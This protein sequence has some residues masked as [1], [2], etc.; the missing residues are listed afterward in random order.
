MLTLLCLV[1]FLPFVGFLILAFFGARLTKSIIAGVG[2]GSV[3]V[4]A[5]LT[6]M[7]GASF[8]GAPP[9][10]D[11]FTQTLWSWIDV[12]NFN[13]AI[14]FHLD[15]LSL[16]MMF[17][18]TFVGFFIHL[19]SVEFMREEEGY[20]RFFAYMNLFVGSMLILVMADNLLLLYLGWE[21]VGLCSYLLIGFWY[22]DPANGYAA[23]KA[24]VVTRVGDTAMAIGLFIL[25]TNLGTLNI[26]EILQQAPQEWMTGSGIAIAAAALLLGGAV[27]KSAQLPLQTWLP[28]AMAGPTPVSALIHAATMVTAGVYLI[29][30]THVLFQLAPI[31]QTLVAVVGALTLLIAGFSAL[32]QR[33][34]KRVLAYSTISQIGYMFLALGVGAYAAAMFH[35]MT[36]AFFKALLFLGAGV[37]IHCLHHEHDMFKMGGLKQRMPVTFWTFL[38]G[39]A[40]LA[41]LP[42]VTAGFYSKDM[43]LWLT[44]SSEI[45]SPWLWAAGL[46]G[47]F[48]TAVYTFRMIFITFYGKARTEPDKSPGMAMTVPLVV[49]AILSIAGGFVET[50]AT[51]GHI[52]AFSSQLHT[53]LADVSALHPSVSTELLFQGIAALVTILGI[54]LAYRFYLQKPQAVRTS[55]APAMSGVQSFWFHGW[56]FDWLYDRLFVMPY[57][58]FANI[59]RGDA[60]DYLYTG[61]ARFLQAV[62]HGLRLTQTGR[63]RNYAAVIAAGTIIIIAMV[64]ML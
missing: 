41:A 15:A 53:V 16:A 5:L 23:R 54:F 63:V 56:C 3:G 17:V 32:T 11:A 19:Y 18:I 35:F 61:L 45:G 58:W 4:A 27:G 55:E 22:R 1:P 52:T 12:G 57:L 59:N 49:L 40:S 10:G 46:L 6:I 60:T 38:I 34:I 8:I 14:A 25:F 7:I 36:H 48:V 37:I 33:D 20:S 44:W 42:L 30:R 31:V 13:P 62:Y 47:A 39:G 24:F 29:A 64:I 26:Q 28:D 2:V 51:L 21:G 9:P 43:I 50:P